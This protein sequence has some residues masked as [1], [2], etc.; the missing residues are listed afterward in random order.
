MDLGS[1]L[2]GLA[3]LLMVS[4]LVA[5][6]LLLG[7]DPRERPARDR[8]A[9]QLYFDRE[10]VLAQL[11]DLDFDHATGKLAEDDYAAQ[12]A[13]LVAQGVAVLKQLDALGPGAARPNGADPSPADEIEA[14]IT[15]ARQRSVHQPLTAAE[16]ASAASDQPN[17]RTGA[18]LTAGASSVTCPNCGRAARPGD[19][20]CGGCGQRL[21]GAAKPS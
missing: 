4:F 10:R 1:L 2:L 5:R 11:R 21:P 18:K 17:R 16:P 14:A 6:P 8:Q 15:A 20:F 12:R 9:D 19:Q 7:G 3:L 13:N